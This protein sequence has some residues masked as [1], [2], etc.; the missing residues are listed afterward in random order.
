MASAL[1]ESQWKKLLKENPSFNDPGLADALK[2]YAKA[3]GKDVD[4]R[5]EAL[6]Q[7]VALAEKAQKQN[8]KSRNKDIGAYLDEVLSEARQERQRLEKEDEDA[9]GMLGDEKAYGA[10]LKKSLIRLQ[11]NPLYFAAALGR[12]PEDHKLIFHKA[13]DGKKLVMSLAEPQATGLPDGI[14]RVEVRR[15]FGRGQRGG[16][17]PRPAFDRSGASAGGA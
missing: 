1:V 6:D 17:A 12:K 9:V 2:D 8:A 3:E 15:L 10:Y 5:L 16:G 7:V 11:K 13:Q 4:E 14:G